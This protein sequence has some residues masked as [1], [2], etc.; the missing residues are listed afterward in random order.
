MVW[1][2]NTLHIFFG[3][4]FLPFGSILACRLS[5]KLV[6]IFG[7]LL[8]FLMLLR[9]IHVSIIYITFGIFK[10]LPLS[11]PFTVTLA[12]EECLICKQALSCYL[13]H[14]QQ[15]ALQNAIG[16][17]LRPGFLRLHLDLQC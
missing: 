6:T 8:P 5:D 2:I 15:G 3:Y 4:Q 1:V 13:M 11:S 10:V 7:Q 17:R 16:C 12:E 14:Y 9:R